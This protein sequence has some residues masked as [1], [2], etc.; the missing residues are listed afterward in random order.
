[1]L[2]ALPPS[3]VT[4]GYLKHGA[5]ETTKVFMH[6]PAPW[7]VGE[8]GGH[9]TYLVLVTVGR[10]LSWRGSTV[11]R[12]V[13]LCWKSAIIINISV[14]TEMFSVIQGFLSCGLP[15]TGFI[16]GLVLNVGFILVL[17]PSPPLL[18]VSEKYS[19]GWA[20]V[21]L[22]VLSDE[23]TL[24]LP[25]LWELLSSRCL[26]CRWYKWQCHCQGLLAAACSFLG[27]GIADSNKSFH[28]KF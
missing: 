19:P 23:V 20:C 26:C 2:D 15:N 14:L 16:R 13:R 28:V 10:C 25:K 17:F 3:T 21:T 12:I 18:P 24:L 5:D 27:A 4:L 22:C 11:G 8:T 9:S 6:L 7:A 1:M